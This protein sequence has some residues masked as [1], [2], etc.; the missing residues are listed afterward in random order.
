MGICG[1]LKRESMQ[2]IEIG[3]AFLEL[4]WAKGVCVRVGGGGSELRANFTGAEAHRGDDGTRELWFDSRAGKTGP[5]IR[6]DLSP[7]GTGRG[8]QFVFVCV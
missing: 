6:K 7:R 2:D 4:F 3:F 5:A 8:D 1:L